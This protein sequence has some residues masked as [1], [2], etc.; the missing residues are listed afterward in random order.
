MIP[1]S[2]IQLDS[3]KA[4]DFVAALL[5][6]RPGY[7]P[8]WLPSEKGADVAVTQIAACYLEAIAQRLNQAPEK[9]KLAFLDLL[10]VQ[11]TPA[12]ASRA[13]IVFRLASNAADFRLPA[14]TRIAAAPPPGQTD[15]I[16][17]ETERATGL[18]AAT[19]A[20]VFSL[21]PGRDQYI[22][23]IDPSTGLVKLPFKPFAKSQLEDTP[24]IIYIAHD[25]MLAL[26]GES[27]VKVDFNLATVG[28]SQLTVFWEYWDGKIWR[29]FLL[30]R[31]ECG[32]SEAEQY[33]TTTGLTRNGFFHLTTDCAK[34]SKKTKGG[35]EAFWIRGRLTERLPLDPSRILPR[36]DRIKLSTDIK[37]LFS[38]TV[39]TTSKANTEGIDLSVKAVT[40]GGM[41]LLRANL[42][43]SNL[44]QSESLN[45]AAV[46]SL[47][48]GRDEPVS[49]TA[50]FVDLNTKL[51]VEQRVEILLADEGLTYELN[52]GLSGL[53]PDKAF[54]DTVAIDLSKAFY[55][56]GVQP[57]PGSAF[58]F[59]NEEIFSK[60]GAK[61][62]VFVCRATPK[63][64]NPPALTHIIAWEY[65]NGTHWDALFQTTE[66][67]DAGTALMSFTVPSDMVRTKINNEEALW[68]RARLVSGG[69][70]V[71]KSFG[72]D[73]PVSVKIIQPPALSDFLFDYS[74]QGKEFSPEHVL[75]Y[76]D[77]QYQDHTEDA[78]WPGNT[79]L[80]FRLVGDMTPALYLGFDKKPPED[81]LGVLFDITEQPGDINGPALLWEYWDGIAWQNLVVHDETRNFR[82]PGIVS[83]IGPDDSSPLARFEK[84]LWWLRARLKEDGPPGEPTI[85]GIFANA[86]WAIQHQTIVDEPLGVS[87]GQPN[88]V[89]KFRQFPVL[90]DEQ[91][92]VREIAGARANVEWR[93]VALEVFG[94]D[95]GMLQDVETML[96]R[97]GAQTDIQMG[98]LRLRRDRN[99]R[100]SEVWVRWYGKRHLFYSGPSDRHYVV[101]RA[102]GR[103]LFGDGDHGKAPPLGAAIAARK[104][105]TGGGLMG[106]LPA[107]KISQGGGDT[108]SPRELA[109]RG[110]QTIHHRGRAIAPQ[111]FETLAK[112][113]NASVA[114]ARAISCRNP[115]GRTV[116]G[117]VTVVII[118]QSADPRPWPSFGLREEV[119]KFIAARAASDIAGANHIFVTGPDYVEVDVNATIV[120]IDPAEAGDVE[121]RARE[122]LE[123]FLHPLLGG[124]ENN[125][126]PAG[127]DVFLSDVAAILERVAGVDYVAELSLLLNGVL[128]RES[129]AVP[130]DRIVV[131]GNLRLK[132]MEAAT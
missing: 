109:T 44:S 38:F 61:V 67:A 73:P 118:P 56:F 53:S 94:G 13:P 74:W 65:W 91:V 8:E 40:Q 83:F 6:L 52:F 79:F 28:N 14:G 25:T 43:P 130:E 45:D 60:P 41:P 77:F 12:Q 70:E 89:F 23:H 78:K 107:R 116:P 99:K 27:R 9:N 21:W 19:I 10:G 64:E 4:L 81:F 66:L 101:E 108:E 93:I 34:T 119:Q 76:N 16:I 36:V 85:K 110:P 7:L 37:R 126:W 63:E 96:A 125:G 90:K 42:T 33:D 47:A 51:A 31:P 128:Q 58:Y 62:R 100:V 129:V 97:D 5:A 68:M 18:S 29:E 26:A 39:S 104:Y 131:A 48:N 20:E 88:R 54:A 112:E 32:T 124:P 102:R 114:A 103:L 132:M 72:T 122:A 87:T 98:D 57:V 24:H 30:M 17:F 106:N 82:L 95:R 49:I 3:R 120:P 105:V 1:A 86:V 71:T 15:Q 117:W 127:R 35:I 59:T 121:R 84:K 92:E 11:L 46:F 80:P 69:F 75:T 55:P 2:T 111:D 50:D 113:A 123:Q 115:E 22:D